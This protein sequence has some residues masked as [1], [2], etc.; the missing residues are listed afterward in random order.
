MLITILL[1][2]KCK[3]DAY[4]NRNEYFAKYSEFDK[5]GCFKRMIAGA[6]PVININGTYYYIDKLKPIFLSKQMLER[7]IAEFRAP[8]FGTRYFVFVWR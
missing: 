1:D 7:Y 6:P 2:K 3:S 5:D 8:I 4:C